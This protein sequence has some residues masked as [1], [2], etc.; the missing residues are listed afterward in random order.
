MITEG[1]PGSCGKQPGQCG[2][3]SLSNSALTG[4]AS[5]VR[6]EHKRVLA[7]KSKMIMDW[8]AAPEAH[9]DVWTL[10]SLSRPLSMAIAVTGTPCASAT[11]VG[12]VHTGSESASAPSGGAR[13]GMKA[14]V[15]SRKPAAARSPLELTRNTV[16]APWLRKWWRR[17]TGVSRAAGILPRHASPAC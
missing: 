2:G 10:A 14:T 7:C 12:S 16:R 15:P 11:T 4:A 8:S 3:T 13:S 17:Y 9:S 6:S 1:E 5:G